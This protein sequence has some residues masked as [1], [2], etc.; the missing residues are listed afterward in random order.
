VQFVYYASKVLLFYSFLVIRLVSE[1]LDRIAIIEAPSN[2]GLKETG[3]DELPKALLSIGLAKRLSAKK[4]GRV[5]PSPYNKQRDAKTGLLNTQAIAKYTVELADA[6]CRV[7]DNGEFPLVLGGDCSILIGN[8]LALRRRGRYGLFFA[9]GH[10]DFYQP[11][12]NSNGEV[13]SS[14]LAFVTG[15][16]P[17]ALTSF[18]GYTPLVLDEDVIVFGFRDLV[19]QREYGSQQ[20]PESMLSLDLASVRR[21]GVKNAARQAIDHLNCKEL[22][23]FWFHLDA[24]VLSDNIMPA[25]DYRQA[26]GLSWD[27]L[28]DML[29][30]VYSSGQVRGLDITIYNPRYDSDRCIAQDFVDALTK[31]LSN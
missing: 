20:L 23:G 31:G 17:T 11:E 27:E 18:E 6:V 12:A 14:E 16:G 30:V 1:S 10:A 28:V 2:L 22:G 13:A 19:E 21:L 15:R 29:K 25:V 4:N 3:V 26:D 24:D 5:E 9:D 8:M 7:L